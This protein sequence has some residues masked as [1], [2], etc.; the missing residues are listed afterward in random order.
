MNILAL[1]LGTKCGWACGNSSGTWNLKPS[2]SESA[3]ERY[4][5]FKAN[6]AQAYTYYKFDYVTYEEVKY[7]RATDAAHV[8]GALEGF[9]QVFCI[10]HGIEFKGVGVTTI[11]KH[12]TGRGMAPK[13]QKKQIMFDAAIKLFPQHNVTTEDQADALCLLDY[14][15]QHIIE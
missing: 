2:S 12:A 9:L 6:L 3:G 5:K 8:Y 15:R 4:R 11:Q 13:G 1:D 10:D 14:S 7:H